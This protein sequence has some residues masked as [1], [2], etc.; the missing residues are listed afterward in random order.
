[1]FAKLT[2]LEVK[3]IARSG[4]ELQQSLHD[5]ENVLETLA[6]DFVA[7]HAAVDPREGRKTCQNCKLPELCRVAELGYPVTD[8][9]DA[10]D[11]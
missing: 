6:R 11:E 1:M 8:E 3:K 4:P 9:M 7:G 2:A 5:W 10:G